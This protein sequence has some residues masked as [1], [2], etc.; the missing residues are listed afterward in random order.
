[1]NWGKQLGEIRTAAILLFAA[2]SLG[3]CVTPPKPGESSSENWLTDPQFFSQQASSLSEHKWRYTAKVGVTTAE[4]RDQASLDWRYADQANSIRLFGPLGFGA[5]R[6]QYD[7]YGVVLSDNK[8]V[9]HQGQSVE[10]LIS[11]IVGWPIPVNA[12][13]EWLFLKPS[14]HGAY[15]YQLNRSGQLVALQQLGWQ[16]N[17]ADYREYNGQM[18]PRKII[19]RRLVDEGD[20]QA[21][22][23]K[24]IT[25]NWQW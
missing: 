3:A 10:A 15:R 8:G 11:R 25:K 24:L 22:G 2:L 20:P 21:V 19:A 18:M 7:Q 13:S 5:V 12:L 6:I 16:I 9:R 23:V 14:K 17:Y 1:M 4:R